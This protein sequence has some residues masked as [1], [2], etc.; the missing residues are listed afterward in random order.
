MVT[1]PFVQKFYADRLKG[2]NFGGASKN[3]IFLQESAVIL[4]RGLIV[5]TMARE[6]KN[7]D[8]KA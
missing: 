1:K 4:K 3:R 2:F 7:A 5:A 6:S 8:E